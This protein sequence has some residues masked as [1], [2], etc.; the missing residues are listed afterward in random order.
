MSLAKANFASTSRAS[1]YGPDYYDERMRASRKITVVE[2]GLGEENFVVTCCLNS[3]EYSKRET[4][5]ES[6]P[7]EPDCEEAKEDENP[8]KTEEDVNERPKIDPRD[9]IRWFG[10][11]VPPSLRSAQSKFIGIAEGPVP[12]LVTLTKELRALEI[13]IGRTRKSI[14]KIEK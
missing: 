4:E 10:L 12:Q 6:V 11:L 8:T 5:S 7:A 2:K 13:E 14:K 3:G 1:R 9:P